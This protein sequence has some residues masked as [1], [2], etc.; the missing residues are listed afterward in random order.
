MRLAICSTLV[1]C[2]LALAAC[3]SGTAPPP[4]LPRD[5]VVAGVNLTRLFDAPTSAEIA[6]VRAEFAERD[7]TRAA[8][9]AVTLDSTLAA[10]D[11]AEAH[12]YALRER[13]S[14]GV[15]AYGVVRLPLRTPGDVVRRP[16]LLVLP[17]DALADDGPADAEAAV[18][19]LPVEPSRREEYVYAVLAWRGRPLTVGGHTFR[20]PADPAAAYDLDPDDALALLDF[21]RAPGREPLVDPGRVGAFGYGRGGGAALL[22][23][24]RTGAADLFDLVVELAGPTDFFLDGVRADVRAYLRGAGLGRLPAFGD[25]VA[26]VIEPLRADT[27]RYDEARLA[28]LRRSPRYFVEP[29]PYVIAAHGVLDSVVPVAHGDALLAIVGT[30]EALYLRQDEADHRSLPTDAEVVSTVTTQLRTRLGL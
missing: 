2:A 12:V 5:E 26:T 14:N 16:L 9:Y 28:L 7:R 8:R 21:V 15:L 10:T 30:T 22:V 20:S 11:G 3:D 18:T 1:A 27:S 29:P 6:S 19:T 4:D 24:S 17:E 13:A 25:V 23:A